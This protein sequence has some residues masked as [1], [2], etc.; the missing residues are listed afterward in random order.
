MGQPHGIEFLAGLLA[1]S[2]GQRPSQ[3]GILAAGN[4][5]YQAIGSG[6]FQGANQI[7]DPVPNLSFWID[8][9]L[10]T[11]GFYNGLLQNILMR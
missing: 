6:F 5:Q 11:Q 7:I 8:K 4:P 10:N 9:G 3:G 2:L 1:G